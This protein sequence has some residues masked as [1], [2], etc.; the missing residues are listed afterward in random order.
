[1]LEIEDLN[2]QLRKHEAEVSKL[3]SVIELKEEYCLKI[4]DDLKKT[5]DKCILA[6]QTLVAE[7]DDWKEKE[8]KILSKNS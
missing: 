3:K 2:D 4:E 8:L 5:N 7:R 1:M 6:E